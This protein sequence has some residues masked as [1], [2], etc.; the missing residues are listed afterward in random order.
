MKKA[1]FF[2]FLLLVFV[3]PLASQNALDAYREGQSAYQKEDFWGAVDA[4]R[5]ALGAN[6]RYLEAFQGE[7]EAFFALGEY[8]EAYRLIQEALKLGRLNSEVNVLYGRI[9]LGQSKTEEAL[10]KFQEVQNREPKNQAALFGLAE[11]QVMKSRLDLAA[12]QFE[13]IRRADPANAR[14]LLSLLYIYSEK[15]NRRAFE[16]V[17]AE[18]LKYHSADPRVH[19]AAAQYWYGLHERAGARQELNAFLKLSDGKDVSG[20]LLQ[21]ELLI[22]EGKFAEAVQTLDSKILKGNLRGGAKDPR[23]WYLRGTAQGDA[24]QVKEAVSAFRMALSFDPENETYRLALEDMLLRKTQPDEAQRV[25]AAQVHF[26]RAGDYSR[27]SYQ[28]LA[29]DEYRR[30]LLLTPFS[31]KG[32]WSRAQIYKSQGLK[33]SF[34]EELEAVART[35]PTYNPVEFQDELE[36]QRSLFRDSLP[37]KW[38]LKL[39]D[40]DQLNSYGTNRLYRPYP[41]GVYYV[42]DD[43]DTA[44]FRSVTVLAET[45]CDEWGA[46]RSLLLPEGRERR[47][48]SVSSFN[49]AFL[50]AR[51]SGQ[52]FFAVLNFHQGLRDFTGEV[53]LYLGRTGR[54]VQTFAVYKKGSLHTTLGLRELAKSSADF[55]ALRGSVVKRDGSRILI[56]LGRRDGVAKDQKG[57]LLRD[58]ASQLTGDKS[59]VSYNET[60]VLGNGNVTAVDDW[61][62]EAKVEKNGFFDSLAVGDEVL[63]IKDPPKTPGLTQLPVSARLQRNILSLR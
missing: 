52:D 20:W 51:D 28:A 38:G 48:E 14:A 29:L 34:L 47:S 23:A 26:D 61:T 36:I 6:P 25:T 3:A 8:D 18:A 39:G 50:K 32:L 24:G 62:S 44:D 35:Q 54:L 10:A 27:K 49:E 41:T 42:L 59:W 12:S 15:N 60:D 37:A 53:K 9:L 31:V 57:I 55:F 30:G 46:W 5:R 45:F 1:S 21:A 19:F 16:E 40:L 13:T 33:T 2:L 7:A 43:S 63:F 58:G 4:Y 11:Y 56:N 22:D 17:F